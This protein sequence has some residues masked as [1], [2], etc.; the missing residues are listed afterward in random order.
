MKVK[1]TILPEDDGILNHLFCLAM[2]LKA[3]RN[4]LIISYDDGFI[5]DKEFVLL[6]DFHS[7]KDL[8]FPY[9]VHEHLPA[10]NNIVVCRPLKVLVCR[11]ECNKKHIVTIKEIGANLVQKFLEIHGCLS[12]LRFLGFFCQ[13]RGSHVNTARQMRL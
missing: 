2:A 7:S 9:D 1:R 11:S 3:L 6:Y 12:S 5:D 13:A 8:D 4:L 10:H